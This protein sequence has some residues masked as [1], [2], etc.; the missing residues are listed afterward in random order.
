MQLRGISAV[1]SIRLSGLDSMAWC[2]IT[3]AL[4]FSNAWRRDG[5]H[6]NC[7]GLKEGSHCVLKVQVYG[8]QSWRLGWRI[9]GV[10]VRWDFV[11]VVV[12]HW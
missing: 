2:F 5:L 4:L 10:H 12:G 6:V 9:R 3:V 8:G 1:V 11:I 7:H